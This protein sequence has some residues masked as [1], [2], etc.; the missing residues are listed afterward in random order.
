MSDRKHPYKDSHADN[1]IRSPCYL[2]VSEMTESKY[3]K[4]N[5]YHIER[6]TYIDHLRRHKRSFQGLGT[7]QD[8]VPEILYR[9]KGEDQRKIHIKM[10]VV[11]ICIDHCQDNG[12]GK[13]DIIIQSNHIL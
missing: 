7:S 1:E 12:R 3:D 13:H 4:K 8:T 2:P 5:E 6:S 9:S 11:H 10:L